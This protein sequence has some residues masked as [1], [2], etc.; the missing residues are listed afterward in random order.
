MVRF[1]PRWKRFFP[2]WGPPEVAGHSLPR[3]VAGEHRLLIGR[4]RNRS[5]PRYS[6]SIQLIIT[7]NFFRIICKLKVTKKIA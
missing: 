2:S 1:S 3:A 4:K 7:L 5:Y 6:F